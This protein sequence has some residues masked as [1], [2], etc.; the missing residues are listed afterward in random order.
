MSAKTEI[1]NL[2]VCLVQNIAADVGGE[3]KDLRDQLA[4]LAGMPAVDLT[5]INAKL[6]TL[7]S[8]LDADPNTEGFQTAQNLI[9]TLTGLTT[10]VASL[11]DASTAAAG[12]ISTLEGQVAALEGQISQI[13]S[14]IA[15]GTGGDPACD[16]AALEASL[17]AAQTALSNLTATDV[18]QASQIAD[19]QARVAAAESGVGAIATLQAQVAALQAVD[20]AQGTQIASLQAELADLATMSCTEVTGSFR[21]AFAQA[22]AGGNG[23]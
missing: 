19:L 13:Q 3:I 9:N 20:A 22:L 17:A 14:S 7:Q 4:V 6:A 5:E 21:A 23:N 11:E 8:L 16:C 2:L 15:N 10:R 18:A 1:Q 12:S